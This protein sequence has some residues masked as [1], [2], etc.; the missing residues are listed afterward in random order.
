[1]SHRRFAQIAAVAVIV[2]MLLPALA[3]TA[4]A[5]ELKSTMKAQISIVN[6]VTLGGK[7]LK[8]GSYWF[9]ADDTKVQ[10]VSDG[11]V[12]A[13]VSVQWQDAKQKADA[14]ALVIESGAVKEIRFGGKTRT[15]L[16]QE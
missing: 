7:Q 4:G 6:A 10:V 5:R 3:V 13:E 15:A 16:V 12:V 11:K 2:A 1:M 9:V 14:S 8:A